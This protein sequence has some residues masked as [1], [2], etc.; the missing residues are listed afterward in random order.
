MAWTTDNGLVVRPN[1]VKGYGAPT[2]WARKLS[3]LER[4]PTRLVRVATYSLDAEYAA[5]FFIRRP[6]HVRLMCHENFST[7]AHKLQTMLPDIEVRTLADLHAAMVLIEPETIYIGS[8]N[9]VKA[10]LKEGVVGV[11]S[12][13][14][15]DHYA[16][17][18]DEWWLEA[19]AAQPEPEFEAFPAHGTTVLG[20]MRKG[21]TNM[22]R[23]LR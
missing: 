20:T 19:S 4:H 22:I 11:R 8:M 6:H 15:H 14:L 16:A 5:G 21:Q 18:F 12:G 9:F 7:E 10:A 13:P 3:W 23:R 17:L 1:E 2:S